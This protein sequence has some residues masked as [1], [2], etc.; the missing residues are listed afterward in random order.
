MGG[1]EGGGDGGAGFSTVGRWEAINWPG[2]LT[3]HLTSIADFDDEDDQPIIFEAREDAD[4]ADAIAPDAGQ[5]ASQR[6]A[7]PPWIVCGDSLAEK[8]KDA[9]AVSASQR[10]KIF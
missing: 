4:I 1:P 2:P 9:G 8:S 7:L 10:A 3:I 5:L 6:F